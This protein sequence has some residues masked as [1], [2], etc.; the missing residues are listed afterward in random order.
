MNTPPSDQQLSQIRAELVRG[1]K[2]AAI[3][4]YREF[5][6]VGLA[7]AKDAVEKMEAGGSSADKSPAPAKSKG[8]LG[9][10]AVLGLVIGLST[11]F[12]LRP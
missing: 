10:L 2:I 11:A 9:V 6:N 5:T 1:N 4:L 12:L 3:K 8:C 7:E